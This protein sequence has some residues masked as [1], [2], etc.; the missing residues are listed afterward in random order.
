MNGVNPALLEKQLWAVHVSLIEEIAEEKRQIAQLLSRLRELSGQNSNDS[1]KRQ[2]FNRTVNRHSL[3]S[4]CS[5]STDDFA[6][7]EAK[8]AAKRDVLLSELIRYRNICSQ[9]RA[10]I[11][12]QNVIFKALESTNNN[13]N[14]EIDVIHAVGMLDPDVGRETIQEDFDT[15][16]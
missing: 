3:R 14:S 15:R 6:S 5:S 8:L 10:R 9:L 1:K 11:E 13:N 12:H 2:A 16:F 4:T 7:E